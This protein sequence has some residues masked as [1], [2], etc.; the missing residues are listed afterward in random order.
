MDCS[1]APIILCRAAIVAYMYGPVAG[2]PPSRQSTFNQQYRALGSSCRATATFNSHAFL[3][4]P[5]PEEV[6]VN[7]VRS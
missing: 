1:T 6:H 4:L 3:G 5:D 2:I 7:N